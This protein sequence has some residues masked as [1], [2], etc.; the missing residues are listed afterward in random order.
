MQRTAEWILQTLGHP[1][2]HIIYG[3]RLSDSYLFVSSWSWLSSTKW[4]CNPA[5]WAWHI[6]C[7]HGNHIVQHSWWADYTP[8]G[9]NWWPNSRGKISPPPCGRT[10]NISS[11]WR[12]M[13]PSHTL[14]TQTHSTSWKN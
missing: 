1:V 4:F 13:H 11:L 12:G 2:P 9:Q 10:L 7:S 3:H 14:V 6:L 5:R 8:L